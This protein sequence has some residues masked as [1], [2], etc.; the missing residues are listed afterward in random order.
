MNQLFFELIR[1]AIGRSVCLSH[2]PNAK[3]WTNLYRAAE[4]QALVGVCFYGAQKLACQGQISYLSIPLKMKWLATSVQIM[5]RNE[6]M[7]RRCVEVQELLTK[8]GF[9]SVILKGQGNAA[10]YADVSSAS[11]I[12]EFQNGSSLLASYRQSGDIDIYVD[13]SREEVIAFAKSL[14][15]AKPD[16]D[17]KHLHL[18]VFDDTEVEVHYVPELLMNLCKNRKLQKWFASHKD[19]LVKREINMDEEGSAHCSSAAIN[20]YSR[21]TKPSIEF[22]LF[23]VLLHA[24][25]HFL[26]EGVGLRQM[27]DYYFVLRSVSSHPDSNAKASSLSRED[28]GAIFREF[29]MMRFA[30]GVMWLMQ[31]VFGLEEEYLL[32]EP[33]VKEGRYILSQIMEGGNFGHHDKRLKIRAKGKIGSVCKMLLHNMH[34]LVHYPQEVFWA[35]VWVVYHFVWKRFL[36]ISGVW[37]CDNRER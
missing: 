12:P 20:P 3:E 18:R 16:W 34:L 35:P 23:Y 30:K 2:T 11:H 33:D 14:G 13:A 10:L 31:E 26:S 9:K 4:K 37:R 36:L 7:T 22:N 25:R 27:M 28:M 5:Q 15:D 24:Y 32:C 1:V 8:A 6:L 19:A 21:F 17:Y 29:G